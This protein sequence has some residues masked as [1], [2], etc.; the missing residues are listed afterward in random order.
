M[1]RTEAIFD[2]AVDADLDFEFDL[3]ARDLTDSR[4]SVIERVSDILDAFSASPDRLLLSDLTEKTGLPRSTAFRL[5]TQLV[6]VGWVQRDRRGYRLGQRMIAVGKNHGNHG[7]IREASA[8]ILLDLHDATGLFV[9]LGVLEGGTLVHYLDRVGSMKGEHFPPSRVGFRYPI[10][11]TSAG[12]AMLSVM[13]PE[14]ADA[15]MDQ[16]EDESDLDLTGVRDDIAMARRRSGV[17]WIQG[18]LDWTK[19]NSVAAP[20][21]GPDGPVAA[22]AL[23]G[24]Q[25]AI[26][27]LIPIVLVAARRISAA[28]YPKWFE[29][30]HR[31]QIRRRR[32]A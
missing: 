15:I 5:L 31:Q 7:L 10:E 9:H 2:A 22:I 8:Q 12:R 4:S 30:R 32:T 27:P 13:D 20:I 29:E 23:A 17:A 18:G 3:D 1:E 24:N 16:R 19:V 28:L 25:V 14:V 26:Q 11:R 21:V 6:D